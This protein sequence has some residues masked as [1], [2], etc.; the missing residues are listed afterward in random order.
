MAIRKEV[1]CMVQQTLEHPFECIKAISEYTI[2]NYTVGIPYSHIWT[3]YIANKAG[4]ENDQAPF[5]ASCDKGANWFRKRK[6][7]KLGRVYGGDYIPYPGDY[8]YISATYEQADATDVGIVLNSDGTLVQF[9]CWENGCPK[10]MGLYNSDSHI[11]GY[12]IPDYED[13]KKIDMPEL[14][15][16]GNATAIVGEKVCVYPAPDTESVRIG[17]LDKGQAVEVLGVTSTGWLKVVWGLSHSG[18]GFID[19]TRFCHKVLKDETPYSKYEGFK[20]GDK[21]QF[22]GG[23]V[24]KQPSKNG[25]SRIASAFVG[26]ITGEKNDMYFIEDTN[27]PFNGWVDKT[28]VDFPPVMGYNKHKGEVVNDKVNVRIGPGCEFT[29][30]QKWP[31]LTVGNLVDVLGVDTDNNGNEWCLIVIEGVKGYVQDYHINYI[32]A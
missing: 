29:K 8:I 2:Q 22:K 13:V 24:L 26:K 31:Q 23:K 7:Y 4:L 19:N 6:R 27:K 5:T 25:K 30:V 20:L 17:N 9:V 15:T 28:A 12:G 16:H 1:V 21:V 3:S 11:I 10:L 32:E 18:Y 14:A